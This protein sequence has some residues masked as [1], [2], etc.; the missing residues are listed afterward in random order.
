MTLPQ[1]VADAVDGAQRLI[2][3]GCIPV[4]ETGCWLWT[5]RTSEYGYGIVTY[6]GKPFRAH[7]LSFKTFIGELIRGMVICHRCDTPS[8]VNPD[9]LFQ[10]TQKDNM[11]DALKKGRIYSTRKTHCAKGHEYTEENTRIVPGSGWRECRKCRYEHGT[12]NN[13]S[14]IARRNILQGAGDEG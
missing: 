3:D 2:F 4:T 6:Q 11:Q 8:C 10:G 13:K 1:N 12:R 5:G 9:H 14:V 7:R